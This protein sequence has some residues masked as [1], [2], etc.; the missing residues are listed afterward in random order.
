MTL[1]GISSSGPVRRADSR[2][3]LP[4]PRSYL[5]HAAPCAVE[6]CLGPVSDL[7]WL[8]PRC[9]LHGPGRVTNLLWLVP[10][11]DETGHPG[12]ATNLLWLVPGPGKL[13]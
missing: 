3:P 8:A 9:P 7:L 4:E 1:R 5:A 13:M 10:A 6:S 2:L 11:A 12:H